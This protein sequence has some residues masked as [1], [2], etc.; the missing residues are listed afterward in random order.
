V[1]HRRRRCTGPPFAPGAA[2]SWLPSAFRLPPKALVLVC[3]GAAADGVLSDAWY[4][5]AVAPRHTSSGH[6]IN[7]CAT[8]AVASCAPRWCGAG[9]RWAKTELAWRFGSPGRVG[10]VRRK[11]PAVLHS[12]RRRGGWRVGAGST[13]AKTFR[14]TKSSGWATHVPF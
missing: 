1:L 5:F 9:V 14:R 4:G 3:V 12:W 13:I 7:V 8:G 10:A 2:P 11:Q 6:A